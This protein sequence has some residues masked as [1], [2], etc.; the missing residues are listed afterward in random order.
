MPYLILGNER[1]QLRLLRG[2]D[3]TLLPEAVGLRDQV[4]R[5]RFGRV[6]RCSHLS[7]VVLH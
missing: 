3:V 5:L 6:K 4:P 7:T 2:Q 1:F